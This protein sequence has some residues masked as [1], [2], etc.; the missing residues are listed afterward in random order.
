MEETS[1]DDWDE[2]SE[3]KS[4]LDEVDGIVT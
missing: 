2:K 3:E 1:L 4:D